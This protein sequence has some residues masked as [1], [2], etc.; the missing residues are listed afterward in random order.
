M[1]NG[2]ELSHHTTASGGLTICVRLKVVSSEKKGMFS[3][4]ISSLVLPIHLPLL[5]YIVMLVW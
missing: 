2:L 4:Y 5:L 3:G 1:N